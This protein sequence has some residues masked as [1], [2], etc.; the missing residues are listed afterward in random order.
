MPPAPTLMFLAL[1]ATSRAGEG[2]LVLVPFHPLEGEKDGNRAS[3]GV[4]LC[5]GTFFLV[6]CSPL[7][8]LGEAQRHCE[9]SRPLPQW[10]SG[11]IRAS[12]GPGAHDPHDP[13]VSS[14]GTSILFGSRDAVYPRPVSPVG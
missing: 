4:R 6:A 3:I 7:A 1:D 12:I 10:D 2:L 9:D 13:E 11:G 5:A 8:P 14:L